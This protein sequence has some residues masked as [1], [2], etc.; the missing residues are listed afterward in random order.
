[1]RKVIRNVSEMSISK[2]SLSTMPKP[3]KVM[4]V[5][6]AYYN[7]DNPINAHMR[8]NDGSLH[9]LDKNKAIEQWS[10]PSL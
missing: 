5:N 6:P 2:E 4:M 7:V 3:Q 1:M 9:I 8:R 10:K